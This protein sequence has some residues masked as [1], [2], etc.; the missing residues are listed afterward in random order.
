M[1]DFDNGAMMP[2][3]KNGYPPRFAAG[4]QITNKF[5][6]IKYGNTHAVIIAG[7]AP[8]I[9]PPHAFIPGKGLLPVR[10]YPRVRLPS[11]VAGT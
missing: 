3:F 9:P 8:S 4:Q 2:S 7:A 11:N 5:S 10:Y 6:A 1:P